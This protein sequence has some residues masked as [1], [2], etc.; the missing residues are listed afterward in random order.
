MRFIL[1][2]SFESSQSAVNT[3]I[4]VITD[5]TG[6][7]EDQIS[8][9]LGICFLVS[10]RDQD[11]KEFFGIPCIHLAAESYNTS[12]G[13]TPQFIRQSRNMIRKTV[14][15]HKLTAGLLAVIV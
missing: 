9:L 5:R 12:P 15:I 13:R 8:F 1:F 3:L 7:I 2:I 11:T 4:G 10:C 6:I 14:Y